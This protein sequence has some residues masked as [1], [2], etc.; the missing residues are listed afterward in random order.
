[1]TIDAERTLRLRGREVGAKI[2]V[3]MMAYFL[4]AKT[5]ADAYA[6]PYQ[7]VILYKNSTRRRGSGCFE[8]GIDGPARR[9]RI[10]ANRIALTQ[11]VA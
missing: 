7:T 3:I 4:S 9:L 5:S 8:R 2:E 11:S 10:R 1:M 6:E